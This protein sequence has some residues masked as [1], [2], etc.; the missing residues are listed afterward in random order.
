MTDEAEFDGP[1]DFATALITMGQWKQDKDGTVVVSDGEDSLRI[2]ITSEPEGFALAS[3]QIKEEVRTKTLPT[4]I[5][6]TL[7][8]LAAKVKVTMKVTPG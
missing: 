6:I 7:K 5:G 3:E 8:N 4:R 2:Q 1:A